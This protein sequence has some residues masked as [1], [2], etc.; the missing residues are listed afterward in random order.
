MA[1][2]KAQDRR[3]KRKTAKNEKYYIL[4]FV[5]YSCFQN[6][7]SSLV[8]K[9]FR[10]MGI[11]LLDRLQFCG[12]NPTYSPAISLSAHYLHLFVSFYSMLVLCLFDLSIGQHFGDFSHLLHRKRK[13]LRWRR[14]CKFRAFCLEW[15]C[16]LCPTTIAI[17]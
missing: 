11:H 16:R 3:N 10:M 9:I 6:V 17:H 7:S 13:V 14:G 5:R 8:P 1:K 15:L 12:P 2:A 4:S